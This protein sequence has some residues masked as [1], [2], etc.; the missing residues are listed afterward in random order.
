MKR[1][2]TFLVIGLLAVGV[3]AF[4]TDTVGPFCD[5]P[6][7]G[8]ADP[9]TPAFSEDL[10]PAPLQTKAVEGFKVNRVMDYVQ[11]P[12]Q[13]STFVG[14]VTS[15][16]RNTLKGTYKVISKPP[17]LLFDGF[18][19][20]LDHIPGAKPDSA[21]EMAENPATTAPATNSGLELK[22]TRQTFFEREFAKQLAN[23]RTA[24]NYDQS[25]KEELRGQKVLKFL[26]L[27]MDFGSDK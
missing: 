27:H 24:Q 12:D 5:D 16:A 23:H 10:I 9:L 21:P 15:F 19:S 13:N 25:E 20:V 22:E 26:M 18:K 17:V 3:G 1:V 7:N 14:E 8:A 11:E 2:S 4:A 6:L